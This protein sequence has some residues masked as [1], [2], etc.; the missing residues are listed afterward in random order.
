VKQS[1]GES[2]ETLPPLERTIEWLCLLIDSQPG[3]LL[4][5]SNRQLLL[6]LKQ[7]TKQLAEACKQLSGL[8]GALEHIRRSAALPERVTPSYTIEKVYFG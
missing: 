4:I 5:E 3:L 6:E 2:T 1:E 8:S 7:E